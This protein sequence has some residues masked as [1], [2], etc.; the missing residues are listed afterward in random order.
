[1]REVLVILFGLLLRLAIPIVI[2]VV[3]V[4]FLK[5]L[6]KRWQEEAHIYADAHP[7]QMAAPIPCWE[8]KNCT[9]EKRSMCQAFQNTS[10]PCWQQFRDEK[11]LLR[12]GC[13]ECDVFRKAPIPANA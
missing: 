9:A 11:G 5:R 13:L 1:M 4:Y 6:D 7:V 10:T 12:E 3:A 8:W 2:T